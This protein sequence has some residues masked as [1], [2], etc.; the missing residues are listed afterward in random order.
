MHDKRN[1]CYGTERC[2]KYPKRS[3][4]TY[5]K[6]VIAYC[7]QKEDPYRI[8]ITVGGN[9]INYPGELTTCTADMTTAKL[10]W[11]SVLSTPKARYMCLNI[12]NFYLTTTLDCYEYMKMPINLFPPWIIDHYDLHTKVVRG[13]IYL[14]MHEAVWGLPQA[15]ILANKLL[16]KHLAPHCYY[17]CKITPG[18]WMHTTRPIMFTLVAGNVGVKYEQQE[19]VD[20]LITALKTKYNLTKD[21]MEDLYCGIK[22]NWDYDQQT[23]NILMPGYIVK[24]LQ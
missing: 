11:N 16:P 2:T 14:Q 6:V 5:A 4:P 3:D 21:W 8:R 9:L 1:V 10:Y 20:H 18:L 24:Q 19:D 22:L 7:P 23:L 13:Y 17:E 15:S 12:G